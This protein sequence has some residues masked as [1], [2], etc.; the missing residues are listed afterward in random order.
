MTFL[1]CHWK[2]SR[3]VDD[4]ILANPTQTVINVCKSFGK[5]LK[6]SYMLEIDLVSSAT[7]ST[8]GLA[9]SLGTLVPNSRD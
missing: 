8:T 6:Y 4:Y 1:S 3:H 2:E 9:I 5:Y 7:S